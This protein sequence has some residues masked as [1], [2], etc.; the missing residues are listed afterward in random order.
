MSQAKE[1]NADAMFILHE[2]RQANLFCI[3]SGVKEEALLRTMH[4][5]LNDLELKIEAIS[6]LL[7]KPYEEGP[8][9]CV[10]RGQ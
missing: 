2:C 9:H 7:V 5:K 10:R 8:L 6:E 3:M 1:L 4:D